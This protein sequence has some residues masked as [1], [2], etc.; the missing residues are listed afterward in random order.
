MSWCGGGEMSWIP[1]TE[2]RSRAISSVTLWAGSWPPSP[3]L[4]PWTILISSSSARI[5]Y[6]VVTP[7]RADGGAT[8][9]GVWLAV[10]L[11]TRYSSLAALTAATMAPLAAWWWTGAGYVSAAVLAMALLLVMR[12]AS[13]IRKLLGGSES[14]IKLSR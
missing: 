6:S 14:R 5:R 3:G 4:A 11:A 12:H 1:G 8:V 9:V 7:N 10:A 13:N 2:W